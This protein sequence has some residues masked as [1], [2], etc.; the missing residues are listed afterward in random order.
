MKGIVMNAIDQR[1]KAQ[2]AQGSS[3]WVNVLLGVWVLISPFILAFTRV[4]QAMWN[5]V[6]VGG[7]V[8]LVAFTRAAGKRPAS[9]L[10]VL[11][12]IWLLISPFALRFV[13]APVA[14]WNNVILGVVITIVA[15][16]ARAERALA[17]VGRP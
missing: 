6:A 9:M 15:V 3:S 10:N 5:N 17:P 11:L 12:G 8:I 2:R 14:L 13:S 1:T 16:R 4:E 7:A